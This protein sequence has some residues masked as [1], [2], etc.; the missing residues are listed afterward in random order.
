MA[1][2]NGDT[3][4]N[5]LVGTS[6][7]DDIFGFEGND[8][9]EITD[10]NDFIDGGLDVDTILFTSAFVSS[11]AAP[12]SL[13]LTDTSAAFRGFTQTLVSIE[14]AIITTLNRRDTIDASGFSGTLTL[15]TQGGDD[16]VIAGTGVNAI[17]LGAGNDTITLGAGEGTVLG[18]D[19]DDTFIFTTEMLATNLWTLDGGLGTDTVDLRGLAVGTNWSY[20][21]FSVERYLGTT[22]AEI[23][24]FGAE[25][26]F[27]RSYGGS[28]LILG[29]DGNDDIDGGAGRDRLLGQAG[30][31][32]VV[33]GR[34]NDFL[35]GGQGNDIV[36]GGI[37]ND[38]IYA[39]VGDDTFIGGDGI[40]TVDYSLD[41]NGEAIETEGIMA[42]LQFTSSV[43][44]VVGD[45]F[46]GIENLTGTAF[47]D[48]LIGDDGANILRGGAGNDSLYGAAALI[49]LVAN[50]QLDASSALLSSLVDDGE[51]DELFGGDGDDRLYA[52]LYD[53]VNGGNGT[54]SLTLTLNALTTGVSLDDDLGALFG[55]FLDYV[56]F[57]A[58]LNLVDVERLS[59]LFLTNFDDY[60]EF[61][62][63]DVSNLRT[64]AGDDT[65]IVGSSGTGFPGVL[66]TTG[67]GNDIIDLSAITTFYF[68]FL[69]DGAGDDIIL[70]GLGSDQLT[71][72]SDLNFLTPLGAGNDV[73]DGAGGNDSLTYDAQIT[74]DLTV[75][76]AN[77][78]L[79]NTGFGS[80][81]V[82]NVENLTGGSGND[83]LRGTNDSNAIDG[84]AGDDNIFAA[85]GNDSLVGGEG[86]DI[87]NGGS[88]VDTV[89]YPAGFQASQ[90]VRV[91]LDGN[92][93]SGL[94]AGTAEDAF[95]FID[96]ILNVENIT[97]TNFA[98]LVFGS[99]RANQI[100]GGGGD[101]DLFGLGGNDLLSG[102]SGNDLLNGGSGFDTASY[103]LLTESPP[104]GIG[105]SVNATAGTVIDQ[106]GNTDTLVGIDEI[107]GSTANDQFSGSAGVDR[108]SGSLGDDILNGNGG[109]DFLNGDLGN[110]QL[111]GG[112]GNDRLFGGDGDDVLI[113]G[114]NNDAISGGFGIDTALY[115][116]ASSDY[117][118][119]RTAD[120]R[121][122]VED[123]RVGTN[124]GTDFLL[125]DVEF[126]EFTDVT[127]DAGLL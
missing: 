40:D 120:G 38:V 13:V 93:R 25:D 58:G 62:L 80:L 31:D 48:M 16:T 102:G 19:G 64:G 78:S 119:S 81:T 74:A 55:S 85:G 34:G 109:R 89:T 104:P 23:A 108:F 56:S 47:N 86:N 111:D 96:T 11:V 27:I 76:L 103:L 39:G 79:Q 5:S 28:D 43:L 114:A 88:G 44:N 33:G 4:D 83:N 125:T 68:S 20:N 35:S 3:G 127:L 101:D 121:L 52:G 100:I 122:R 22:G 106:W 30:D 59:G 7:N 105:I 2:V 26:N 45:T 63:S 113:G 77:T 61:N 46:D 42:A 116:G 107:I 123:N 1:T 14:G 51:T 8:I 82:T 54:D 67:D 112:D 73:F 37:G 36:D 60:V 12:F 94:Q 9:I 118:F 92:T 41:F 72:G 6:S 29:G 10:G 32:T 50:T 91:N 57:V 97:A 124:D 49:P 66:I 98:D 15:N 84:G 115:S 53:D 71:I 21:T 110:D 17:D 99:S 126:L 90:G 87:L 24:F 65:V 117:T 69:G 18:G 95:G 75:D 70:G